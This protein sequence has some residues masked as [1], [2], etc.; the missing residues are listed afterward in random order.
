MFQSKDHALH[1]EVPLNTFFLKDAT[2]EVVPFSKYDKSCVFEIEF[3]TVSGNAHRTLV[4]EAE[5]ELDRSEWVDALSSHLDTESDR[6]R[7]EMLYGFHPSVFCHQN[8]RS[9]IHFSGWLL[10]RM[11]TKSLELMVHLCPLTILI[12]WALLGAVLGA[13]FWPLATN[14]QTSLSH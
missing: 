12:C 6:S 10:L 2:I 1:G 11:W 5:S 4:L 14:T 13:K 9:F 3:S 8:F 7:L